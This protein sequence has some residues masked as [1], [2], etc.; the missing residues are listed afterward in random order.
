MAPALTR[1]TLLAAGAAGLGGLA[2]A[3][4]TG[5]SGDD[6]TDGT[7]TSGLNLLVVTP[8]VPSGKPGRLVFVLQDDAREPVTPKKATF[9]FG[10]SKERMT[11]PVAE[12]EIRTDAAPATSYLTL[13]VELSPV[14][15]V[16]A[17]VT[18]DGKKATAPIVVVEKVPGIGAGQPLPSVVT[19]S[20][21]DLAGME[22][23]C[24]R[25]PACPL[26]DISLDKALAL[27]TPL[28]VLVSTP[29]FCQTAVCG[30]VLEVLLKAMPPFAG[31]IRFLHLEVYAQRPKEKLEGTPLSPAVD[32]FD[33]ESEPTLFLV[34]ADGVVRQRLDGVFGTGEVTAALTALK[35]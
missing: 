1:R 2:L 12:A 9:R 21:G 23:A 17:E 31:A 10:P 19:P 15:T 13:S 27:K 30:P 22:V 25:Q 11:S 7:G 6:G 29:A 34:G 35:G 33:L 4:C 8:A 26:H 18:A 28:A 24:T 32:A 5:G 16:W 20:P 3:A 14:G